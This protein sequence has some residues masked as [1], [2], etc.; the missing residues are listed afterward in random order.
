MSCGGPGDKVRGP[1]VGTASQ[2]GPNMY[3]D[4]WMVICKYF[5]LS[6]VMT[7]SLLKSYIGWGNQSLT[8]LVFSSV[9]GPHVLLKLIVALESTD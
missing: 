1:R 7:S 5:S 6:F 9:F 8:N 2:N 3:D 4:A